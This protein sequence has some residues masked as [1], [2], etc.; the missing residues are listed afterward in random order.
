[1]HT[2]RLST[3]VIDCRVTDGHTADL[4]DAAAFWATALGRR[5][6]EPEPGNLR[7]R[8][9]DGTEPR[10]LIQA[11]DHES[12]IHLDLESDD[13]PA[14]VAR[15]E[16]L[17]AKRIAE[18]R[19]WVVMEAPTG[20]RFCVVPLHAPTVPPLE[21]SPR[22]TELARLKGRYTGRTKT[23]LRPAAPPDEA[24]GALDVEVILGGRWLRLTQAG[25]V[26]G[27]PHAGEL[28]LGFHSDEKC[29]QATWLDSF[30]TGSAMMWSSG[31]PRPDGVIAVTGSYAAGAERWGWRT[32]LHTDDGLLI[33]MFNISPAGNE[34]IAIETHWR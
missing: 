34:T 23:W 17:G 28:L 19:A 8:S 29:Y 9:L 32:E 15:L 27:K 25:S 22:H 3:F 5:I 4:D 12:R 16:S 6:E 26:A 30:H 24:D 18:K 20:Q 1:M 7:Y 21:P 2:S 11:V 33:R 14:E 10:L 31:P 13:I